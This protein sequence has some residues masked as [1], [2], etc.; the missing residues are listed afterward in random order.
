MLGLYRDLRF[1]ST[2]VSPALYKPILEQASNHWL[3]YLVVIFQLCIVV[4]SVYQINFAYIWFLFFSKGQ[5]TERGF[6]G[7]GWILMLFQKVNFDTIIFQTHDF[8]MSNTF[9]ATAKL[10]VT[11]LQT[12][13]MSDILVAITY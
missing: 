2:K 3:N 10:K 12:L 11:F 5:Q 13:Y 9:H 8:F 4:Y 1:S 6:L 7:E